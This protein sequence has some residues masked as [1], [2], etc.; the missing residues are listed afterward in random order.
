MPVKKCPKCGS[1]KTQLTSDKSKHGILW[2]IL[3]G[4]YYVFWLMCKWMVGLCVLLCYDWW[5]AIIAK[6]RGKGYVFKSKGWFEFSTKKYYCHD[7][8][9]NFKG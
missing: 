6:S 5:M 7:C 3:F 2:F 4:L 9:D 8:G 1:N